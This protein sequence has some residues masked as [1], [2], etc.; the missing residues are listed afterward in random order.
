[1]TK[2]SKLN[3]EKVL[4]KTRNR[5]RIYRSVQ[6]I[7]RNDRN[8]TYDI[9]PHNLRHETINR[10]NENSN[11][12]YTQWKET[13]A[14]DIRS[15]AIKYNIRKRALTALLKVLVSNGMTFLPIDSRTLLKTPR[16][17]QID[18]ISGGHYW[19]CGLRENLT[20][21]FPKLTENISIDININIDGLP[22]FKGS[23]IG[24]WPILANIKGN[25]FSN[26][27]A[28]IMITCILMFIFRNVIS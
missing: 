25:T 18:S 1:M 3:K 16:N 12:N 13:F 15:W 21:I 9:Q 19:H 8:T 27:N 10:S 28:N 11:N 23:A 6:A 22:L 14:G 20:R 17:V 7:L 2:I 26:S 4:E 24:F 5:V